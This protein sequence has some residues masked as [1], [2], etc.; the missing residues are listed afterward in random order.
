LQKGTGFF[1]PIKLLKLKTMGNMKKTKKVRSS[2]NKEVQYSQ[3]GNVA[4]QFLVKSQ[5]IQS[6]GVNLRALMTYQLTPVPHSLAL[7]DG[8][9]SKTDKSKGMHYF[10]EKCEDARIPS[11]P[12][13]CVVVEDGNAVFH[14]LHDLPA[15]FA[16]IAHKVLEEYVLK[17]Q[18]HLYFQ[19]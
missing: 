13:E 9:F 12:N 17:S 15:T 11:N 19:H 18:S 8:F 4:F 10:V 3:Q 14:R 16:G 2:K 1:D 6:E 5:D 7:A